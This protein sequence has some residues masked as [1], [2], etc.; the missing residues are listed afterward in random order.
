MKEIIGEIN[1][2]TNEI[3]KKNIELQACYEVLKQNGNGK[4]IQY[5]IEELQAINNQLAVF[6]D[7]VGDSLEH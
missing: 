1:R 3:I 4:K 5:V 7:M 2:L 6:R